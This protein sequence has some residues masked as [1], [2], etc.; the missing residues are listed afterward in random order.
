MGHKPNI[1]SSNAKAIKRLVEDNSLNL[2]LDMLDEWVEKLG[3]TYWKEI[4]LLKRRYHKV[5][6]A[7]VTGS[8]SFSEIS[9]EEQKIGWS[10]LCLTE[11]LNRLTRLIEDKEN[12]Q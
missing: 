8:L 12:Q 3:G 4:T 11:E 1:L 5:W 2:A 10:I 6:G 7:E 9:T